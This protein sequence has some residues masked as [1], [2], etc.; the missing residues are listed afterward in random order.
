[1]VVVAPG[2][3]LRRLASSSPATSRLPAPSTATPAGR[4]VVRRSSMVGV[5]IAVSAGAVA[6]YAAATRLSSLVAAAETAAGSPFS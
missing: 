1:M 3:I 4:T 6:G 2:V 5:G